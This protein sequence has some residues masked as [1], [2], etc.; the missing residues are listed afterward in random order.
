MSTNNEM[1][2][3]FQNVSIDIM[4][5]ILAVTPE[6]QLDCDSKNRTSS[7]INMLKAVQSERNMAISANR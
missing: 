6:F 4:K 1:Y 7:L 2:I 3:K 5:F